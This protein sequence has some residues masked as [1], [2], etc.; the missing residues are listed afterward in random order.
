MSLGL[1]QEQ[2]I[3]LILDSALYENEVCSVTLNE[4]S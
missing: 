4:E 2:H 1:S 3:L